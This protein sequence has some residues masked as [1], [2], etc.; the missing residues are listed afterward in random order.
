LQHY[1]QNGRQRVLASF[2]AQAMCEQT[3]AFYFSLLAA[4]KRRL[5]T[6]C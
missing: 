4:E 6:P 2:T 1:G 5:A 3:L